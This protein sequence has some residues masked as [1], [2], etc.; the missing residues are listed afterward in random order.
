MT[1]ESTSPI[2][3]KYLDQKWKFQFPNKGE[4]SNK[5]RNDSIMKLIE[6]VE[7]KSLEDRILDVHERDIISYLK[8]NSNT[9]RSTDVS[10]SPLTKRNSLRPSSVV[11]YA[12]SNMNSSFSSDNDGTLTNGTNEKELISIY[13][14]NELAISMNTIRM[15]YAQKNHDMNQTF[16]ENVVVDKVQDSPHKKDQNIPRKPNLLNYDNGNITVKIEEKVDKVQQ[17][18]ALAQAIATSNMR[19]S[20]TPNIYIPADRNSSFLVTPTKGTNR[21]KDIYISHFL[22]LLK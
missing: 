22:L 18:P 16:K 12:L 5:N 19:A 2:R 17:F 13:D 9:R 6:E 20:F 8:K 14:A 4:P 1:T 7:S 15:F 3:L 21:F 10:S 11:A